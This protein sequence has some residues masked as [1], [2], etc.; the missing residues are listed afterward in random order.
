MK[1][2]SN[3]LRLADDDKKSIMGFLYEVMRLMKNVVTD[4]AYRSSKAYLKIIDDRWPNILLHHLHEAGKHFNMYIH[5]FLHYVMLDML[6]YVLEC[7]G[8]LG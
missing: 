4:A 6:Y 8:L 1:S 2:I 3:V 5:V 7:S